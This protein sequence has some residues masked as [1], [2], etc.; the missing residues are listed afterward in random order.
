MD[1][2]GRGRSL[3]FACYTGSFHASPVIRRIKD[4]ELHRH[5][6]F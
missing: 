1:A 4:R 5:S 3:M 6:D 2:S